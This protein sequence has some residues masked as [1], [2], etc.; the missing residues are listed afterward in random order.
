MR[1]PR[2][3]S[4]ASLA[5]LCAVVTALVF[6]PTLWNGFVWDDDVN[7]G[8]NPHLTLDRAGLWWMLTTP[9]EIHPAWGGQW[10]PLTWFSLAVDQRVWGFRALGYHLTNVLLHALSAG[11]LCLIALRLLTRALPRASTQSVRVGAIAATLVWALHPLRVESVAWVTE[12]RDVLS[13]CFALLAVL[14]Y[15]RALDSYVLLKPRSPGQS[16][17]IRDAGRIVS[18][19]WRAVSITCFA[20]ALASKTSVVMAPLV[21]LLLDAYPLGRLRGAWRRCVLEKIPYALLAGGAAALTLT[22]LHT[23]GSLS[24]YSRIERVAMA[25]HAAIFYLVKTVWPS[26]LSLLYEAPLDLSLTE[27]RFVGA[28]VAVVAI[29]AALVLSRRCWPAGLVVWAAYLLLLAPQSGL[30]HAG[31]ALA[32]DRYSYLPTLAPALLLGAGVAMLRGGPR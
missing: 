32:A 19:R 16:T 20:L 27:P 5:L 1:R 25:L 9:R 28:A 21:L 3:G 30:L 26:H 7:I 4:P 11:V 17:I 29:T 12:R 23:A 14:T 2:P 8:I 31:Y 18:R 15:L 22:A 24:Q 13:G 6:A 10:I